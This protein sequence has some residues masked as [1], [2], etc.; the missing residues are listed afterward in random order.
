M[1]PEMRSRLSAPRVMIAGLLSIALPGHTIRLCDGS[2]SVDFGGDIFTGKDA[3]YGAIGTV[4]A[5]GESVGD[6][7]PAFEM[8]LLPPSLAAAAALCAPENQQ[9]AVR[10]WLAVIDPDYGTVVSS[11][12]LQ[13]AGELDDA[14]YHVDRGSHVVQLSVASVWERLFEPDEGARL[15]DG[16]HQSIF[17]GEMGMANMTGT[18]LLR[19]WGPGDKPPAPYIVPQFPRTG[20]QRYF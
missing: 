1:T 7:V 16:F 6:T 14:K 13:F 3:L 20:V 11:P 10:V 8:T 2:A 17:P 12:D 5:L 9:A 4:E 18:P 15:S 19:L